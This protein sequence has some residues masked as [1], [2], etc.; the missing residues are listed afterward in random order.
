MFIDHV[1][2]GEMFTIHKYYENMYIHMH[3]QGFFV[4]DVLEGE[5]SVFLAN[6][7]EFHGTFVAGRSVHHLGESHEMRAQAVPCVASSCAVC[8]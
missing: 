5:A 1:L 4:D 3:E 6:G 8:G 7:S 2:Q